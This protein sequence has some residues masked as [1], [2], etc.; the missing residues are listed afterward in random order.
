MTRKDLEAKVANAQGTVEK[1][2]NVLAKHRA[3]LE[4]LIA[5][6]ADSYDIRWKE[7]D[8]KGAVKKL[9]EAKRIL[10]GWEEKL[11]SHISREAFIEAN[12]P[13]VIKD[14]LENWKAS[15]IEYYTERRATYIQKYKEIRQQEREARMEALQTL[16]ELERSRKLYEGREIT[17]STLANLWPRKPVE[18]F[19]HSKGL[20]YRQIQKKLASYS[21]G[22]T[23]RLLEIRD[24]DERIQWL[25]GTIEE[26][27]QA[28]LEDLIGRINKVVGTI[29]DA[30]GLWIGQKGEINGIIIGTEGKAKIE[31]FGVAGYS[32][33]ARRSPEFEYHRAG[34]TSFTRVQAILGSGF[35]LSFSSGFGFLLFFSM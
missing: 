3:Q 17:D 15:A 26:E 6:G 30:G 14:F 1:R 5:K 16:P 8:I 28:K 31:T 19:L 2:K 21:D 12:A 35:F 7:D 18:E 13:Q 4:K 27:K 25:E 34:S 9:E 10:A 29:T 23:N 33:A 22:I 32:P 20:D 11:G 24:P